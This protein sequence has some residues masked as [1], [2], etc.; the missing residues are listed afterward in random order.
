[1]AYQHFKWDQLG[2]NFHDIQEQRFRL[3]YKILSIESMMEKRS[4]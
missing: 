1:M 4:R 2:D 3:K